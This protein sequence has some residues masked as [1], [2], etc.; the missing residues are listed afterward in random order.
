MTTDAKEP[1]VLDAVTA[2][3]AE[4]TPEPAKEPVTDDTDTGVTDEGGDENE[5][6]ETGQEDGAE[7]ED[8]TDGE[9]KDEEGADGEDKAEGEEGADGEAGKTKDD[10]GKAKDDEAD[11]TKAPPA[12]P[13]HVNDPIPEGTKKA[14]RERITT[15]AT[16]VKELAPIAQERDEI[17]G[18]IESTGTTPEQYA[19]TLQFLSMYNSDKPEHRKSALEVMKG[20]VHELAVELNETVEFDL[21]KSYPDLQAEIDEKT[22]TP[23]RATEIARGRERTRLANDRK[24]AAD[25]QTEQQT[26]AQQAVAQ[27]KTALNTLEQQLTARDGAAYAAKKAALLP[28][29]TGVIRNV[30][31]SQWAATFLQA[32]EAMPAPVATTPQPRKQPTQQPM[33]AKGGQ[34]AGESHKAPSTATEAVMQALKMG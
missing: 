15:L 26:T 3:V 2:A 5:E 14:T 25:Q 20:M 19:Q 11:K 10:A 22:L 31:P 23:E 17:L 34:P 21:L 30:H 1:T 28:M 24:A 32:Y 13:D 29:L 9:D 6:E 7:G 27:G 4:V 12:E 16:K 33:R 8:D 18:A